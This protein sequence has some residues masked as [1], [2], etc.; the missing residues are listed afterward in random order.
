M[1]AIKNQASAIYAE[2]FNNAGQAIC[3][4]KDDAS[5]FGRQVLHTP[6]QEAQ[7]MSL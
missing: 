4:T 6:Q 1:S 5:E 7:P 3:E 2:G